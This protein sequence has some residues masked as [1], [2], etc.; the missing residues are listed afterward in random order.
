MRL[1]LAYLLL[2]PLALLAGHAFATLATSI[3]F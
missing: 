1:Q 3:L 2:W